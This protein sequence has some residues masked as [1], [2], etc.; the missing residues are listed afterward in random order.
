MTLV[1]A[2]AEPS[3]GKSTLA[4][5][6]AQAAARSGGRTCLVECDLHRPVLAERL[7]SGGPGLAEWVA[8][9]AQAEEVVRRIPGPAG[10]ELAVVAAGRHEPGKGEVL[11]G[12]AFTAALASLRSGHDLVILDAPPLLA[13]SDALALLAHADALVLCARA[14]QTAV[15]E[16][17]AVRTTLGRLPRPLPAALVVTNAGRRVPVAVPAGVAG[18]PRPGE[19]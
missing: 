7:G 17:E 3:A 15:D 2:S 8:G 14:G 4:L 18:E 13:V 16:L 5:G 12:E 1:V 11:S 10:T 19:A 9:A 6:L